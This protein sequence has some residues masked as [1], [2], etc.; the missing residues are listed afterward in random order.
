MNR[1]KDI[2]KWAKCWRHA[3][4][5]TH[6]SPTEWN[7]NKKISGKRPPAKNMYNEVVHRTHIPI[8]CKEFHDTNQNHTWAKA[9]DDLN[10]ICLPDGNAI[11]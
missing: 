10:A 4:T 2:Y 9:L 1:I 11:R 3:H 7:G 5:H 8:Q 6:A